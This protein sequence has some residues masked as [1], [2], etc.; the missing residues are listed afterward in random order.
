MASR[1]KTAKKKTKRTTKRPKAVAKSPFS[2]GQNDIDI[3]TQGNIHGDTLRI[4]VAQWRCGDIKNGVSISFPYASDFAMTAGFA[5]S[6]EDFLRA[7]EMIRK[8][9]AKEND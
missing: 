3:H 5:A 8:Y 1:S 7:A 2:K 9:D 4:N 6:R